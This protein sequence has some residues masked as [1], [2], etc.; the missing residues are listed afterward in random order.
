MSRLLNSWGQSSWPQRL[1]LLLAVISYGILYPG[2]TEPIMTITATASLFGMKAQLFHETRSIWETVETLHKLGYT[3]VAVL[4][5]SF[6]I[7]IPVTKGLTIL[8][9]WMYPTE[10]RW[11]FV[12]AISKWSMADV[13]VVAILVAFFTAQSTAQV[14][15]ELLHGFYWFAGFCLLSIVSGQLLA[16]SKLQSVSS[17]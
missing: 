5:V 11:R 3:G 8:F 17:R 16:L 6:S 2:V 4:I 7:V 13:F 14:T 10:R 15:A 1:G 9:T 12:A